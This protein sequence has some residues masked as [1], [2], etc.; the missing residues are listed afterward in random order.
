[1]ARPFPLGRF[2]PRRAE[3]FH[4]PRTQETWEIGD[5]DIPART[6]SRRLL[7]LANAVAQLGRFLIGLVHDGPMQLL[8]QLREFLLRLPGL[9]KAP[10]GLAGMPGA[11][12]NALQE[13]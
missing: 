6:A 13:R 12:M 7:D 10:R 5:L 1:M 3:C 8:A 2:R 4:Q 9:R 11:A